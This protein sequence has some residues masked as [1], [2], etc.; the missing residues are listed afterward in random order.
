MSYQNLLARADLAL[1]FE[2]IYLLPNFSD[3]VS[4]KDIDTSTQLSRH[5]RIK[6]PIISSP[7]DTISDV[8][9]C[10]ALNNIG[11]AGILHR[12]HDANPKVNF[13]IRCQKAKQIKEESGKCYI[14]IGLNDYLEQLWYFQTLGVDLFVLDI[15]HGTQKRIFDFIKQY[16]ASKNLST[17][18][19]ITGNTLTK[20]SVTRSVNLGADGVRHNVGGGKMCITS[21]QTGI[22]CPVITSLY[23]GFKGLNNWEL[24]N[25]DVDNPQLRPS[26]LLDGGIK[27]AGDFCKA[28]AAGADAVITGAI[29]AGCK[30]TP[31]PIYYKVNDEYISITSIN[32]LNEYKDKDFYEDYKQYK[33]YRGQ[34][35]KSVQ[36]DFEMYDGD[37]QNLFVEGKEE[38]VPYQDKSCVDI[39]HEY[40]NGL[41]SCASYLGLKSV[42]QMRGSLWNGVT[43]W[44]RT[45]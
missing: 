15:A 39:V 23:Y 3:I 44:V 14:A 30:E 35:S 6:Y 10:A 22:G 13:D 25:N 7:M 42:F 34:A 45:K 36:E 37:T 32:P 27:C 38:Y 11:A 24:N 9:M 16:K 4:R 18:D 2:D 1:S 40:V 43:K 26:L 17:I 41:R 28:I 20:E 21:M 31:G 12:F 5:I 29:F 8:E 33:L 19:L